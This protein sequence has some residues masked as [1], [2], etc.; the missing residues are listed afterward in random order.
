MMNLTRQRNRIW[1]TLAGAVALAIAVGFSCSDGYAAS[2]E[3]AY[4]I[5]AGT[6]HVGNG[7]VIEDGAVVVQGSTIVAVGSA[8]EI[9]VPDGATVIELGDGSVSPG[10][11][12]ANAQVEPGD[13]V[14]SGPRGGLGDEPGPA[15]DSSPNALRLM[16]SNPDGH[17]GDHEHVP[18]ACDG[19]VAC[20]LASSHENL[21]PDQICP[22]CGGGPGAGPGAALRAAFAS[23][24]GGQSSATEAS[25]EVVPHTLVIDT[26]RFGSPDWERLAR[27]G[28]TT[29]FASPD[30]AAVIGP[31]GAI[32]H[33]AGPWAGRIVSEASDVKATIGTD[34]Y[35]QGGGNN[36]PYRNY[37]TNRTR[38][39]NSR[40]GVAWV[41][42]KA[43]YDTLRYREGHELEG[44]DVPDAPAMEVLSEVF[45]GQIPLRIQARQQLDIATALRV[46]EEFGLPFTLLEATEAYRCLDELKAANVPVIFGPIYTDPSGLRQRSSETRESRLGTITELLDAGIDT[47]LSAQD[48]REE[49]GLIRQAMYAVRAGVEAETA[50]RLVTE[51][52]ARMLGLGDRLGTVETGKQAD[53]VVWSGEPLEATSKPLVVMI[54]GS[55]VV[56]ERAE[57]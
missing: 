52:P 53:L 30:S 35:S 51:V 37:V 47:A 31:R 49:D 45:A 13:L 2:D 19:T 12:D 10:L 11:I 7:T 8:G 56:D 34:T 1:P 27:G 14:S 28:V 54:K 36:S 48:L 40:M 32:L 17:G 50:L 5:H 23:G 15:D 4:Y 3:A 6:V 33:T 24:V 43:M 39:P 18:M 22:V 26:I 29:V 16:F 25:S 46:S 55:V 9:A 21:G 38:R 44:T 57:G 42:R 20:A 41:F